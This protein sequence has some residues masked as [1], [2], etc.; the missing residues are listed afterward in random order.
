MT[1][2]TAGLGHAHDVDVVEEA[3]KLVIL[4]G[5]HF[6]AY[7]KGFDQSMVPAR[8]WFLEHLRP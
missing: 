6:E 3:E 2:L 4:L 1:A 5:G 8:D 7:T